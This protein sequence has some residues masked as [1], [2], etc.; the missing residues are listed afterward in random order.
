MIGF[1][2]KKQSEQAVDNQSTSDALDLTNTL[3]IT[4]P[5]ANVVENSFRYSVIYIVEHNEDGVFGVSLSNASQ[6][7]LRGMPLENEDTMPAWLE[8]RNLLKGGPVNPDHV[9][10]L[11]PA[12]AQQNLHHFSNENLALSFHQENLQRILKQETSQLVQIGTGACGWKKG[13]LEDELLRDHWLVLPAIN[14]LIF[15]VPW[16]L[17][18]MNAYDFYLTTISET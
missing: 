13:Q 5:Y 6:N 8:N 7:Q 17:I 3:L 9:W 18:Y 10:L 4:H 14:E 12:A 11:E 15:N 1:E 2:S 16:S